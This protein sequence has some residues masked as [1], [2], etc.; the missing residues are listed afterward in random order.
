MIGCRIAEKQAQR[1][2]LWCSCMRKDS[3]G[4]P[5][6]FQLPGIFGVFATGVGCSCHVAFMEGG[7]SPSVGE[8]RG[9]RE[10]GWPCGGSCQSLRGRPVDLPRLLGLPWPS[11]LQGNHSS[12]SLAV[13]GGHWR[14]WHWAPPTSP[15]WGL[16]IARKTAQSEEGAEREEEVQRALELRREDAGMR[17]WGGRG[18]CRGRA[19]VEGGGAAPVGQN[20][21]IGVFCREIASRWFG[22]DRRWGCVLPEFG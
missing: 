6:L 11:A 5:T 2:A 12:H 17:G 20:V 19:A 16:L 8:K 15:T 3:L 18:G 1:S 13:L 22:R 21:G 14:R 10:R 9:E 4:G 7:W